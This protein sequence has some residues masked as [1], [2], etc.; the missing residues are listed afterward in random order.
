LPSQALIIRC[1]F[2]LMNWIYLSH[3][4]YT[5][6]G[7]VNSHLNAEILENVQGNHKTGKSNNDVEMLQLHNQRISSI[8]KEIATFFPNIKGL[9]FYK[10]D[11]SSISSADLQSFPELKIFIIYE[12]KIESV[13]GDLF[14]FNPKLKFINFDYNHLK[15]VGYDLI[16]DLKALE[17]ADFTNSRCINR[18]ASTLEELAELNSQLPTSCPPALF[19]SSSNDKSTK[20]NAQI[21]ALTH[22]N[23][24]Q[25]SKIDEMLKKMSDKDETIAVLTRRVEEIEK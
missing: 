5:C 19:K 15:S 14:K 1:N 11:I 4:T 2:K 7:T 25:S 20:L 10:S 9:D 24:Q 17:I 8:P 18:Y 22:R 23:L 21:L 6:V 12:N 3:R 13:D 16:K